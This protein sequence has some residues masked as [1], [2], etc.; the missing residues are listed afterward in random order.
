VDPDLGT[1]RSIAAEAALSWQTEQDDEPRWKIDAALKA[2]ITLEA[3]RELSTIA[4]LTVSEPPQPDL[5]V[6]EPADRTSGSG[7]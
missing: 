2:K 1:R 5:R 7:I 4:D 3:L 6:E